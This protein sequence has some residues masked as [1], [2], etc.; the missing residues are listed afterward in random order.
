MELTVVCQPLLDWKMQYFQLFMALTY[1]IP[2]NMAYNQIIIDHDDLAFLSCNKSNNKIYFYS[3]C[4]NDRVTLRISGLMVMT[5]GCLPLKYIFPKTSLTFHLWLI[6]RKL[7]YF[8]IILRRG[9]RY[10]CMNKSLAFSM[11]DGGQIILTTHPRVE[12]LKSRC[13]I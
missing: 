6:S 4:S 11:I 10:S 13:T 9:Y 12:V 1:E 3:S 2:N 7:Y 5:N 8:Q